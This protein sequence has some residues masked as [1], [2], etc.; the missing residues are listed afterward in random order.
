MGNVTRTPSA[1]EGSRKSVD[2]FTLRSIMLNDVKKELKEIHKRI[3]S[4]Y[5]RNTQDKTRFSINRRK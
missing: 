4:V 5:S 1:M 3:K 2:L